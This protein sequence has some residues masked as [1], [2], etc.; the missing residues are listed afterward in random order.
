MTKIT[1][2]AQPSGSEPYL[3][4]ST[5]G[6][7]DKSTAEQSQNI[8]A[9]TDVGR[10]VCET[11][12]GFDEQASISGT[13]VEGSSY[14]WGLRIEMNGLNIDMNC[15]SYSSKPMTVKDHIV[16]LDIDGDVD[17]IRA[18]VQHFTSE[19]G[20]SP[21]EI[22]DWDT[23]SKAEGVSKDDVMNN[24]QELLDSV[25]PEAAESG[26]EGPQ[27]QPALEGPEPEAGPDMME[28]ELAYSDIPE[29]GMPY[30][31]EMMAPEME[32]PKPP[33][34]RRR[35]KKV[36]KKVKP[37]STRPCPR[38]GE[39]VSIDPTQDPIKFEC[40]SCGLKG[41]FKRKKKPVEPQTVEEQEVKEPEPEVKEPE[42]EPEPEEKEP[43]PEPEEKEPEPE[44]EPEPEVK[45]PEPE[46][47]PEEKEPEPEPEP[48]PEP[49][50]PPV[51][52]QISDYFDRA[53]RYKSRNQYN[54]A[55]RFYDLV[56]DLDPNHVDALN[57]KGIILWANR[58][59]KLAINHFD[60]VLEL[61]PKNSEALINKAA[62]MNRL[63]EKDKA[64]ELYDEVLII[65]DKNADAWSNKGVILFSEHKYQ[66]AEECFT[67][68][69]ENN[70]DDEDG[71]FNLGFV[72]EKLERFED[73]SKAYEQVLKINPENGEAVR[74]YHQ[75]LRILR[76]EILKDWK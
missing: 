26:A 63:G 49:E 33:R 11:A 69:V 32:Q 39:V 51:E 52:A 36:K 57:N 38:C 71:W 27:D 8:K 15:Q 20:Y 12:Q 45:E 75:C 25:E 76:Q 35:V 37:S 3:N 53:E 58:K 40:P 73:A 2:Y 28:P 42:P 21:F 47:E 68:A 66:E 24:W 29:P 4:M 64:L 59:Y 43:E 74:A 50:Q 72:F 19:L 7:A 17:S 55:V 60:K 54:D 67:N 41:K 22:S 5:F 34:K 1:L 46:P 56:L 13:S 23:F 48:I 65:D 70:P 6:V 10:K 18:F 14:E 44:P 9:L 30:E 62:S 16:K 61:D 31:P